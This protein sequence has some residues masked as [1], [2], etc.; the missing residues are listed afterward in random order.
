VAFNWDKRVKMVCTLVMLAAAIALMP[1]VGASD[2][3]SWEHDTFQVS[4]LNPEFVQSRQG[5]AEPCYG[6]IAPPVD[7]SRLDAISVEGVLKAGALPNSFDWRSQGKVT[8]VKSQGPCGTCWIFGTTSVLES[9]VLIGDNTAYSFSEQ[10]VALCV[11]RSWVYLYDDPDEPCGISHG[12]GWSWLAAEVFIK[13]GVVLESCDP[14]DSSGLQCD[15]ACLCDNCTPVEVVDGYRLVTNDQSQTDLIKEA[16]YDQG[17]L[18]MAYY[19]NGAH[20]YTDATYGAVYDCAPSPAAN[21]MVSVVGWD[22]NVPHFETP[23]TGAWLVKNSWGTGFGDS[24]YLW[25]AY[26]SSDIQEI[27][28]LEYK[29]YDPNEKLYYWDEAGFVGDGGYGDPSAWMASIFTSTQDG[30]LTHVDFWTTSNN[31]QY[32]I[33][34]YLD[35]DIS[36]GLQNQVASQSGACQELGYYSVPLASPVSL[37]SGQVF[38]IAVKMTT[39]GYDNPLPV[40]EAIGGVVEPE[41][42]DEVSYARYGDTDVWEDLA[43]YGCNACLRA[44]VTSEAS[45][46][47]MVIEPTPKEVGVG[48][49]FTVDIGV[50]M[51]GPAG[52]NSAGAHL[53]FDTTYLEVVSVTPGTALGNVLTNSYNNT[54][55]TI[56]Y[57]AGVPMGNPA[58]TTDFVVATVEFQAKVV[59][60]GTALTFVFTPALRQ[61]AVYVGADDVLDPS[62]VVNGSVIIH[63]AAVLEGEIWLQG[64]PA[65]PH[66]SWITELTVTFLQEGVVVRT[67]N[68]TTDDVGN[69]TIPAVAAGTYDI[70]VK[71]PRALSELETGVVMVSGAATPVNFGILREGD[72]DNDDAISLADYALLY[73]AY[74]SAPGDANWN[75]NCD[76]NRNEAVDLGDY[77]LLYANYGQVGDC[78]SP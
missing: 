52:V 55:G 7:L 49:S 8:P 73:A 51:S 22:D 70:C 25:L 66:A 27:A 53:D 30:C 17:P 42:Q 4:P 60:A 11:D 13:K 38:T 45:A 46:A 19:H 26:N 65:A 62:G 64:R 67:E 39:P 2:L 10:S 75:D 15:G 57:D 71:S 69:F 50:T 32:D 5:P 78:Y 63:Q 6:Y 74:G 21:H 76:F 1:S 72:A 14:Y 18:T 77:A 44:R 41:I 29:D 31:A 24:G 59:T 34:V 3:R 58:V 9:A 12:G 40:E 28:Y 37:T 48:E 47:G 61:T 16:V 56:D 35:G 20:L 68:V 36:N 54:A 33:Y 23:G 43:T